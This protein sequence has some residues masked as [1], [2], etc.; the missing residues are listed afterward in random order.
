MSSEGNQ[1]SNVW[2]KATQVLS[3]RNKKKKKKSK[4]LPSG[5]TP[6]SRFAKDLRSKSSSAPKVATLNDLGKLANDKEFERHDD[7]ISTSTGTTA[8]NTT[9][10]ASL[11][12]AANAAP[13]S[14]KPAIKS[15]LPDRNFP[16]LSKQGSAAAVPKRRG[17]CEACGVR[18]HKVTPLKRTP[19]NNTYVANGICLRC[20]PDEKRR[21]GRSEW[22]TQHDRVSPISSSSPSPSPKTSSSVR[23]QSQSFREGILHRTRSTPVALQDDSFRRGLQRHSS[24]GNFESQ[25]RPHLT[26]MM[27]HLSS[28]DYESFSKDLDSMEASEVTAVNAGLRQFRKIVSSAQLGTPKANIL[29]SDSWLRAII[30]KI[31]DGSDEEMLVQCLLTFLTFSSLP[32]NYRKKMVGKGAVKAAYSILDSMHQYPR[33]CEVACAFLFSMKAHEPKFKPNEETVR[34]LADIVASSEGHCVREYALQTL[35]HTA[36]GLKT[37][38]SKDRDRTKTLREMMTEPKIT[39]SIVGLLTSEAIHEKTVEAAFHLW[40]V[41]SVSEGADSKLVCPTESLVTCILSILEKGSQSDVVLESGCAILAN[42]SM[43]PSFPEQNTPR[44]AETVYG[45][46]SNQSPPLEDIAISGMHVICNL[47]ADP[48]R[49]KISE[50]EGRLA[51][52]VVSCLSRYPDN[53]AVLSLASELVECLCASQLFAVHLFISQG[54][55]NSLCD[56]LRSHLFSE[57]PSNEIVYKTMSAIEKVTRTEKGAKIIFDLQ[58]LPAIESKIHSLSIASVQTI[59]SS[60]VRNAL[61][62]P[63]VPEYDAAFTEDST[64]DSRART[65]VQ[66]SILSTPLPSEKIEVVLQQMDRYA[67]LLLVQEEGCRVLAESFLLQATWGA[68]ESGRHDKSSLTLDMPTS[69]V[70]HTVTSIRLLMR[71]HRERAAIQ[72]CACCVISNL[73]ACPFES[74]NLQWIPLLNPLL[75]DLLDIFSFGKGDNAARKTAIDLFWFLSGRCDHDFL[76]IFAPKI[77]CQIFSSIIQYGGDAELNGLLLDFLWASQHEPEHMKCICSES[78]VAVL[79]TLLESKDDTVSTKSSE[80]LAYLVSNDQLPSSSILTVLQFSEKL[81]RCMGMYPNNWKIQ[82]NLCFLLR[83]LMR[84]EEYDFPALRNGCSQALCDALIIH[85]SKCDVVIH[86]C[87][88]LEC[89]L[90]LMQNGSLEPVTTS[91]FSALREVVESELKNEQLCVSA[92]S[93][94]SAA[95]RHDLLKQRFTET[96]GCVESFIRTMKYHLGSLDLQMKGCNVMS[97]LSD[98]SA[99]MREKIAE[100]G[101]IEAITNCMLAHVENSALQREALPALQRLA[102]CTLNTP[103]LK[104]ISADSAVFVVLLCHLQDPRITSDAFFALASIMTDLKNGVASPIDQG[105]FAH[106]IECMRRF[107]VDGAVQES[108]CKLLHV[109]SFTAT[110]LEIMKDR[111]HDILPVI[112]GAVHSFPKHCKEPVS[113]ILAMLSAEFPSILEQELMCFQQRLHSPGSSWSQQARLCVSEDID[114]AVEAQRD[115]IVSVLGLD[116]EVREE[117]IY[118]RRKNTAISFHVAY[119]RLSCSVRL[120]SRFRTQRTESRQEG[121]VVICSL[122]HKMQGN[123]HY[124]HVKDGEYKRNLVLIN[125]Y[126][127]ER[128][129]PSRVSSA[130]RVFREKLQGIVQYK[131]IL[132]DQSSLYIVYEVPGLEI[133]GYRTLRE[134]I[135]PATTESINRFRTYAFDEKEIQQMFFQAVTQVKRLH[136]AGFWHGRICPDSF[137][138]MGRQGVFLCDILGHLFI[139]SGPE[140]DT[141]AAKTTYSAPESMGGGEFNRFRAD[142]WSLGASLFALLTSSELCHELYD[143]SY[144]LFVSSG[145]LQDDVAIHAMLGTI[146]GEDSSQMRNA[147]WLSL[148]GIQRLSAAARELLALMLHPDPEARITI[149]EVLEH[150]WMSDPGDSEVN[151]PGFHPESP[152]SDS[153]HAAGGVSHSTGPTSHGTVRNERTGGDGGFST[154]RSP[155]KDQ[156]QRGRITNSSSSERGKKSHRHTDDDDSDSDNDGSGKSPLYAH[157]IPRSGTRRSDCITLIQS[158]PLTCISN[159]QVVPMG[160]LNIHEERRVLAEAIE[161]ANADIKILFDIATTDRIGAILSKRQTRVLHFSG[162]AYPGCLAIEDALG[163][164]QSLLIHELMDLVSAGRSRNPTMRSQNLDFVFVSACCSRSIGDAFVEANVPHV[165]CCDLDTQQIRDDITVAFQKSLYRALACGNTLSTSFLRART[166]IQ[167]SSMLPKEHLQ[168]EIAKICLLPEDGDHDVQIFFTDE[169]VEELSDQ[170]PERRQA[171]IPPPPSPFVGR[172]VETYSM[173]CALHRARLVR[174]SGGKGFGKKS[175]AKFHCRFVD[176]RR[177][178]QKFEEVMWFPSIFFDSSNSSLNQLF[179]NLYDCSQSDGENDNVMNKI[180]RLLYNRRILIVLESDASHLI[181]KFL[182]KLFQHN[183]SVKV[184]LIHSDEDKY[185]QRRMPCVEFGINVPRLDIESSVT[186]FCNMCP[187]V[188]NPR[189]IRDSLLKAYI[190]KRIWRKDIERMIGDG[191][192]SQIL[193]SSKEIT[194]DEFRKLLEIGER[195]SLDIAFESRA[196]L[197]QKQDE[198]ERAKSEA[199]RQGNFATAGDLQFQLDEMERL[200]EEYPDVA[201]MENRKRDMLHHLRSMIDQDL[202]GPAEGLR[203]E[204]DNLEERISIERVAMERACALRPND[205]TEFSIEKLET[206]LRDLNARLRR[207]LDDNDFASAKEMNEKIKKIEN[208]KLLLNQ[209]EERLLPFSN[210]DTDLDTTKLKIDAAALPK[211][212]TSGVEKKAARIK[213]EPAQAACA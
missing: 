67:N 151:F 80:L 107:P 137:L 73:L 102:T 56:G 4:S 59:L 89:A 16:I 171:R 49:R 208:Q 34:K 109:C 205:Y 79:L 38:Q 134:R 186:L 26:K 126:S 172:Q 7:A 152:G 3:G 213:K 163:G 198:F 19:L 103:I 37:A 141:E 188:D 81:I 52:L 167:Y 136:A 36:K 173:N 203:L 195:K 29:T 47:M 128:C 44:I 190:K 21:Q 129:N 207:A 125:K 92:V 180:I 145:G 9:T 212:S 83:E 71:R 55:L 66:Q 90:S 8:S 53:A 157:V 114:F 156:R 93:V 122:L 142:V 148:L 196:A 200:K 185:A 5:S 189:A 63:L 177:H 75:G 69:V 51:G 211:L 111:L 88:A 210:P 170:L 24:E 146:L 112:L 182:Q 154:S 18:T 64:S 15:T 46:L 50:F 84:I 187:L 130:V 87:R 179:E 77:L 108:G 178:I 62:V 101:G 72:S 43:H 61:V 33:A 113:T 117:P 164:M 118:L 58:F 13:S 28:G 99:Y 175:L 6:P 82:S 144:Q 96:F 70:Q 121:F 159:G 78:G 65:C 165:V 155:R 68:R 168:A 199:V 153:R 161:D 74:G 150:K 206:C 135:L 140:M 39:D 123:E 138:N 97:S 194:E 60:I 116:G 30:S 2:N 11:L 120:D 191:I 176:D 25:N 14:K 184:I 162:H 127:M 124:K 139:S 132:Q 45:L 57:N 104:N 119:Q 147:L 158:S 204:L 105:N 1:A 42:L 169:S 22:E 35:C 94:V 23:F 91:L 192:P 41:Y 197:L 76:E 183:E 115:H 100:Y 143:R 20:N 85:S 31:E 27:Q 95:C 174:V 181:P 106:V 193:R 149:D 17:L 12:N 131:E 166:E 40:W 202:F 10:G 54:G 98:S 32:G 133:H 86:A 110:N 201:A 209:E 160:Q 48:A